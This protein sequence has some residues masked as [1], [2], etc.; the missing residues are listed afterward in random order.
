[1]RYLAL[2]VAGVGRVRD[3]HRWN[4]DLAWF[5]PASLQASMSANWCCGAHAKRTNQQRIISHAGPG[6]QPPRTSS[7]VQGNFNQSKMLKRQV[8][9]RVGFPL[10]LRKRVLLTT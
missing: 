9:G 1:M 3:G 4:E 7:V 6:A 2:Y 10:L 5:A 8:Y